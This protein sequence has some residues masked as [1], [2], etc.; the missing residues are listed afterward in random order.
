MTA[1]ATLKDYQQL[2]EDR[3]EKFTAEEVNYRAADS[4]HRCDTCMHFY[5]RYL[6][7]H[8]TCEIFRPDDDASVR[9]EYTCSFQTPDGDQ[10]PLLEARR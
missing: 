1:I 5:T 4:D 10:F 6:D 3:P 7:R 8:H 9:P 2:M